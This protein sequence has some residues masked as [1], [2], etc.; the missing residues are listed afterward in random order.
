M[1]AVRY[2]SGFT[3]TIA[4][5]VFL[6]CT[7]PAFG[8]YAAFSHDTASTVMTLKIDGATLSPSSPR[9]WLLDGVELASTGQ[10]TDILLHSGPQDGSTPAPDLILDFDGTVPMDGAGRWAVE[11]IGPYAKAPGRFGDG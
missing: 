7:V 1:T 5:A 9:Q 8:Q 3:L 4:F 2:G 10:G 11:V 6:A